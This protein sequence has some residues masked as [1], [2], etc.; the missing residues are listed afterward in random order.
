M[1][2]E[3]VHIHFL[4]HQIAIENEKFLT[5]KGIP[6]SFNASNQ[7]NG[8]IAEIR[9]GM[10]SHSHSWAVSY[11]PP[12]GN[13]VI[14]LLSNYLHQLLRSYATR[15]C[16]LLSTESQMLTPIV[17]VLIRVGRKGRG[18]TTSFTRVE[19]TTVLAAE[20]PSTN[21]PPNLTPV[22]VGPPS[23]KGFRGPSHVRLVSRVSVSTMSRTRVSCYVF[24][25]FQPDPDG[26]RTEI[27]C[28]ACGGHL[29][30]VFKWEGKK[31]PTDERH[32]VNSVSIKF[33]AAETPYCIAWWCGELFFVMFSCE[34]VMDVIM[35]V[36]IARVSFN[37]KLLVLLSVFLKENSLIW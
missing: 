1:N 18:T 15:N 7:I 30:H 10:A 17:N 8:R 26:R 2:R 28:T 3:A 25:V 37:N 22:A 20:H 31:V 12:K 5:I 32:C 6:H 13:R 24:C 11:P 9:G 35:L 4:T 19:Y 14:F 29:G 34:L 33:V 36:N 16:F 21:Q 27:T 23:L